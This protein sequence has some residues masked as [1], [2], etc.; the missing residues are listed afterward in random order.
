MKLT[1]RTRTA[2][3]TAQRTTTHRSVRAAALAAPLLVVSLLTACSSD[4]DTTT[5]ASSSTA[6]SSESS[7]ATTATETS[8]SPKKPKPTRGDSASE[9]AADGVQP[10]TDPSDGEEEPK[11]TSTKASP[12]AQAPAKAQAG[13]YCGQVKARDFSQPG[14]P[15][16][17]EKVYAVTAGTDCAAG[18]KAM[19]EYANGIPYDAYDH[20]NAQI[21]KI[22]GGNCSA[23]TYA[24]AQETN[25]SMKCS[26]DFGEVKV[27]QRG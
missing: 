14:D 23:P 16:V 6:S 13:D 21:V 25:T 1:T 18:L 15:V 3:H 12:S 9:S 8:S 7:T 24:S 4:E 26:G 20:G 10:G 17:D 27:P 2:K 19:Q 11:V 22:P 5:A